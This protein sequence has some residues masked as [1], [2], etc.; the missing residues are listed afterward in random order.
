MAG[1]LAQQQATAANAAFQGAV[2]QA[3]RVAA[4]AVYNEAQNTPGHLARA[5]FAQRILTQGVSSILTYALDVATDP[6]IADANATD[7]QIQN[8]VSSQ[9]N[10]WAGA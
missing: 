1:T 2:A 3:M 6:G 9:W 7:A 8:A 5:Q 10:A 4:I